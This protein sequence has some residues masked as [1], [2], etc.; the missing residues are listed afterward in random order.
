[1]FQER[2][3]TVSDIYVKS[4]VSGMVTRSHQQVL[5]NA[6]CS[7]GLEEEELFAIDRLVRSIIRGRL[8]LEDRL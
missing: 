4:L 6:I 7:L 2:S 5:K 1:M 3:C 8:H